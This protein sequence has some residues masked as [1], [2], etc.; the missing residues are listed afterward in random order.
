MRAWLLKLLEQ[1]IRYGLVGLMNTALT[2]LVIALLTYFDVNA[3]VSNIVGFIIGLLNS[4]ILNSRFTF[5]NKTSSHSAKKFA[6]SFII[7]YL[8]NIVV[9]KFSISISLIPVLASQLIAMVSYNIS[10]FVLMKVWVFDR[11]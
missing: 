5:N 3:Y 8:L 2:F 1:L 4:Y 10:L 9:L 7:A 11:D 6:A